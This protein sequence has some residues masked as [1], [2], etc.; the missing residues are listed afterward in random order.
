MFGDPRNRYSGARKSDSRGHPTPIF[1]GPE[2]DYRGPSETKLG[3]RETRLGGPSRPI[4]VLYSELADP[5]GYAN[6]LTAPKSI[7]IDPEPTQTNPNQALQANPKI[8][9]GPQIFHGEG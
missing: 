2:T 6:A 1:W 9:R 5:S 3:A 7:K 8:E 4:L